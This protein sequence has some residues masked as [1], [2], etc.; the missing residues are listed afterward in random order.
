MDLLYTQAL[1]FFSIFFVPYATLIGI[2]TT[3]L[4][5]AAKSTSLLLFLQPYGAETS[6]RMRSDDNFVWTMLLLF[7]L[8]TLGFTGYAALWLKPSPD[9]GPFQGLDSAYSVVLDRA[10]KWPVEIVDFFNFLFSGA[11][12]VTLIIA[13]LYV[14]QLPMLASCGSRKNFCRGRVARRLPFGFFTVPRLFPTPFPH[15]LG[16]MRT[17]S[18]GSMALRGGQRR[19][20]SGAWPSRPTT[21]VF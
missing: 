3:M 19:I 8:I 4:L 2:L 15:L 10:A 9:C 1:V 5:L 18:G 16:C 6:Y 13:L 17:T 12:I 11:F 20:S 7:F 14:Y 21:S